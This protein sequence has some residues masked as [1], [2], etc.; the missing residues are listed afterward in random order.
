MNEP[1]EEKELTFE[2]SLTALE[3][4]VERMGNEEL[5]LDE[6][7]ALY[8]EGIKYLHLCQKNMET[9][10]MKINL[11]NA[12]IKQSENGERQDG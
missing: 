4:I 2:Q 11:L 7:I 5:T 6:M 1:Q 9:A 3:K 12:R 10:E 8:E